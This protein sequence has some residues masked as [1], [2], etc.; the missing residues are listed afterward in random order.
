VPCRGGIPPLTSEE[1]RA[2]QVQ[3]PQW[4]IVEREG[5]SR[6]K[7]EFSFKDFRTALD[8]AIQ[9]GELAEKEQHHPDLYVAW[10]RVAVEIWTHKIRGLHQNDFILAAKTDAIHERTSKGS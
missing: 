9:V 6:L 2:L 10:G 7:R 1:A 3:V 5:I 4:E 8:F